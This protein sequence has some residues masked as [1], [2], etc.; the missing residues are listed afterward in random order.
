MRKRPPRITQY[1]SITRAPEGN[2]GCSR[3]NRCEPH[4]AG[5]G[6]CPLARGVRASVRQDADGQEFPARPGCGGTDCHR[7]GPV[8]VEPATRVQGPVFQ[9]YGPRRRR[10]HRVAGP[11]GHQ[12]QV[13]RRRRRHSR[14][15]RASPR[16]AP[17]TG[18]ARLAEG[19]QRGF[20]ADGKPEAGRVAISGTG[21]FPA[22]PRRRTGEIDRIGVRRRYGQSP[23]GPAET[24]GIR[25][26]PAKTDGFRAAEPASGPR[27]GPIAGQRHRAPGGVQRAGIASSQCHRGRPGRQLAV[28]PGTGQGPR[29]RHQE[30]GPKP[31]K[32]R[33]AIAAKRDQA[34]RIDLAAHRRRRQCARRSDG[35]RGFLAKRAGGRN[36]QAELAAGSVHHPQ[37]ANERIDGRRQCQPIRRAGR[38]VEPAAGRGHGAV[39]GGSAG[40]T[41]RRS[42]GAE[43]EGIDDKLR[44]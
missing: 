24:A 35:R 18:R 32:V 19:R 17:E 4:T 23:P 3:R 11:T 12:A 20:R 29:Q 7:R 6:A 21:Q 5:T 10:H 28:E 30:P 25:A 15:H 27:P 26:R 38:P 42:D 41:G 33:A 1:P 36:L 39:D 31:V 2:H 37:P 16:C 44:S 9:L 34:S 13:F 8:H 14:A 22:R 40:R 43:P